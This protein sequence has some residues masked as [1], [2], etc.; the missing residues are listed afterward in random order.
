MRLTKAARRAV[1]KYIIV[2]RNI[3]S[4]TLVTGGLGIR[5]TLLRTL[6]RGVL[7]TEDGPARVD[8]DSMWTLHRDKRCETRWN[9]S[10]RN[11]V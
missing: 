1:L 8:G 11:M 10:G 5:S 7:N 3:G 6:P 9:S 2:A 4:R